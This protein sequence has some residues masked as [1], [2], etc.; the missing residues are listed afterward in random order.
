MGMTAND[1]LKQLQALLPQGAAW[2]RE[3]DANIT[4]YLQAVADEL[5][6]VEGRASVLIDEAD[7]RTSSEMLSD[8]ERV[9]GLP[10][11]CITI[12]QTI[13][14]R[15]LSIL[16]KLTTIGGQSR[17]YFIALAATLG[18]TITI[19]EFSSWHVNDHVNEPMHG[20]EWRFAWQVNGVENPVTYWKVTDAVNDPLAVWDNVALECMFNRLK[21]LHTILLFNYS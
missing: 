9:L 16:N 7:P 1:Y 3:A 8:W 6:R 2:P 10:D 21:P 4:K 19:T 17:A 5:A 18:Q 15:R 12:A 14:Q 20:L 13:T 11:P